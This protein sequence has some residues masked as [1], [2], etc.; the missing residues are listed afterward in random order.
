MIPKTSSVRILA[1]E[2][3]ALMIVKV[4]MLVVEN[5][6]GGRVVLITDER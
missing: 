2:T 5:F 1:H 3:H 4:C 6:I